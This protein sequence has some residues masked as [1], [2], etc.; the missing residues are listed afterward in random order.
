MAAGQ[1]LF[2]ERNCVTCHY[3]DSAG[4]GP[5]LN[6]LPGSHRAARRTA[7]SVVADDTYLRESILIPAARVVAGY[8]PIMP[9]Y[10]GQLGE[11]DV[12]A[13]I[14]YIKSLPPAA[15]DAASKKHAPPLPG[16]TDGH[17]D[18]ADHAAT[19]CRRSTT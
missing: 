12:A 5:V 4:R 6:G 7:D 1:K 14:A 11:E 17:G 9:T 10:Q 3:A 16:G 15:G 13:L 8:Q 2:T 19:S 18:D